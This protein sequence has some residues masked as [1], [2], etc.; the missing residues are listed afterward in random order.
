M[1]LSL[2]V[3][4][5]TFLQL[6]EQV[7]RTTANWQLGTSF[8]SL[9]FHH[10]WTA[11]SNRDC[12]CGSGSF[13]GDGGFSSRCCTGSCSSW[14]LGICWCRADDDCVTSRTFRLITVRLAY[15]SQSLLQTQI[16]IHTYTVTSVSQWINQ[17]TNQEINQS[18]S[19]VLLACEWKLTDGHIGMN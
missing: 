7:R 15:S 14:W 6:R 18:V 17:S 5:N 8:R 3:G 2:V 11:S 4:R 19:V 1:T 16:H 13:P 9:I 10:V 12:S